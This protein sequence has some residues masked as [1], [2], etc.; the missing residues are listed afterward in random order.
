MARTLPPGGNI[1]IIV[2]NSTPLQIGNYRSEMQLFDLP[3]RVRSLGYHLEAP[4]ELQ[5]VAK[6]VADPIHVVG[7]QDTDR[8]HGR[9]VRCGLVQPP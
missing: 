3:E 5:Q 1:G 6:H 4:V 7:E 2:R 9:M 8:A